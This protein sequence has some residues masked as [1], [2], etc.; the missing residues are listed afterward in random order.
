MLI[1]TGYDIEFAT[2]QPVHMLA[3]LHI[4]PERRKDLVTPEEL[5][6]DPPV[7]IETY[8]DPFGNVVS[9]FTVPEGGIRLTNDFI[10]RDSGKPDPVVRDA[11]Q[12]PVDKLPNDVLP[13]LLESRY[14]EVGRL[15]DEAFA[16]IEGKATG[17][18]RAQALVDLA[19]DRITFDYM[20]ADRHRT[21]RGAWDEEFGVCRDFAHLA[22]ALCRAVNIPARYATGYLGDIGI[23]PFDDPMD[24]SAWMEVYLDGRWYTFDARHN[25]PRIGR[26]VM[27]YGR[28]ATDAAITTAFG[29]T[30]LKR[31]D[32]HTDEVADND[33]SKPPEETAIPQHEGCQG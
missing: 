24:F 11:R 23:D 29:Q 25:R 21:A 18:A 27:A 10:V 9:R 1:R 13:F 30:R 7:K 15:A 17:W 12:V 26:I 22:I 2:E 28:D 32:I 5:R 14:C 20:K 8:N 33:L 19:H 6:T 4:R 16:A 31:F 3:L